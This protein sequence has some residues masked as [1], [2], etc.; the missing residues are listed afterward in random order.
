MA[1]SFKNIPARPT[2]GVFYESADAGDYIYNKKAKATFC[3]A[4]VCTNSS[5]V[6]SQSNL[7][8]LKRS[9][10][11]NYYQC[12]NNVNTADLNINL[13]TKLNLQNAAFL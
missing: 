8:L 11:L 6:G 7:L 3:A 12:V 9:N 1:H 10:Y 2:F 5:Q 13:I 4:N